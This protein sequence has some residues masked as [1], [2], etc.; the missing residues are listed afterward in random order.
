MTHSILAISTVL[1]FVYFDNSIAGFVL[2][3]ATAISGPVAEIILINVPH[4]YKY[5]HADVWGICSWV[6]WVYF[7]GMGA[8]YILLLSFVDKPSRVHDRHTI[9]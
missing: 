4:L 6:P 5:T 9:S 1:G 8:M 7:L 2:A 3:V